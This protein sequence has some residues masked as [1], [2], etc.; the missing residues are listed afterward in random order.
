MRQRAVRAVVV[1]AG[2]EDVEEGLQLGDGGGL[3]GLGAQPF[4]HRLLEAFDLAA[5]GGA[6]RVGVLL[7]DVAAAQFVL[8]VVASAAAAGEAGGVDQAVVGERARGA[9]TRDGELLAAVGSRRGT[10][11]D[12]GQCGG[13]VMR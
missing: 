5:G 4:L 13:T 1:V 8:E 9:R 11:V 2:D 6:V 3:V 12:D 7:H 10:R